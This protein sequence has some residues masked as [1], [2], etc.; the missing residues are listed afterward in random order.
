M[1]IVKKYEIA[2]ILLAAHTY[3]HGADALPDAERLA[4]KRPLQDRDHAP[5]AKRLRFDDERSE[6][7]LTLAIMR[8]ND[9]TE[10]ITD[11]QAYDLLV[12]ASQNVD[13]PLYRR[14]EADFT[15]ARMRYGNRT[16]ALTDREAMEIL[17]GIAT[18]AH[19][20]KS[21]RLEASRLLSLLIE[22]G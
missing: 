9:R 4:T 22:R 6:A 14:A 18:H 20:P 13:L 11:S 16:E 1:L 8:F 17:G 19:L 12:A 3:V 15:R 21:C 5:P 10:V 2:L 7:D